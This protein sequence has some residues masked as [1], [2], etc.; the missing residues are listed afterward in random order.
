MPIVVAALLLF[1]R[2]VPNAGLLE[3]FLPW[4]GLT[5]P[6]LL[7]RAWFRSL[8][9]LI[10]AL[11][12]LVVWFGVFGERVLPAP[13]HPH[14]LVAVQHNVSDENPDPAGT[15]RTLL[16]SRPDFIGLEEVTPEALPAYRAAFGAGYPY[17]GVRGTVALWS[18]HPLVEARLLDIRPDS[19]GSDWNRGLRAVAETPFGEIA[20]YVVHL[21]SVRPD[22]VGLSP[23]RLNPVA[24]DSA[25][26]DDSARKL[27]AALDAEPRD[28]VLLLGDLNS[29]VDDRVLAPVL[30]RVRTAASGFAFSW[31]A[32]MPL[33]RV[34]HVMAGGMTVTEVRTLPRTGSDH[35]P[36]EARLRLQAP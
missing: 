32:R 16:E 31:P 3:N 4:L 20:V 36:V 18:R 22:P 5:I 30:S 27:T 7:A 14:Q 29:T 34:D 28:R 21:P 24:L 11:L 10:T 23:V 17:F 33:A 35:L 9:A 6:F 8:R 2:V 15:V 26:R 25:R 13:D 1:H 19:L 12:P